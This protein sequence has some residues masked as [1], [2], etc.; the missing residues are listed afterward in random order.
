MVLT[1][2][3]IVAL[4]TTEQELVKGAAR[5]HGQ[6]SSTFPGHQQSP[7][8][9]IASQQQL[10][11][12]Q[13]HQQQ[14]Q[15]QPPH[16]NTLGKFHDIIY[17]LHCGPLADR[18]LSLCDSESVLNALVQMRDGSTHESF[19]NQLLILANLLSRFFH[20][21]DS[22]E[23]EECIEQLKL[24]V[25]SY[26]GTPELFVYILDSIFRYL[27][28]RWARTPEVKEEAPRPKPITTTSLLDI[29]RE[30]EP[31]RF[32]SSGQTGGYMNYG[33]TRLFARGRSLKEREIPKG[34][35]RGAEE[36]AF[37]ISDL[38]ARCI[39][40]Q[41]DPEALEQ[42]MRRFNMHLGMKVDTAM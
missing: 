19:E 20:W 21:I 33:D 24:R 12:S 8:S 37:E 14:R 28:G 4:L 9:S 42:L 39:D 29:N 11:P 23:N 40:R 25:A 1:V 5:Q 22:Q 38:V 41:D 27:D 3:R 13:Q 35:A 34:H 15:S 36:R 10:P 17:M 6:D 18:T 2:Q 26:A 31:I 16:G 32:S 30:R 7:S